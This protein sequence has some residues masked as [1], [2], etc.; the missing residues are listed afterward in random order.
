MS[1]AFSVIEHRHEVH[2]I[3][4]EVPASLLHVLR[5]SEVRM[6]ASGVPDHQALAELRRSG[7]LAIAV[8]V[9]YGGAGG[10]AAAVNRVAETVATVNPSVAIIMFQHFAVSARIAEWGTERQKAELLPILAS[11]Q[12]LAASAWSE[13]G[14][15]AAKKRLATTGVPLSGD[16]W[17][18]D[19]AKSFT[20]GAGIA[21][22][23]LVLVQTSVAQDDPTSSY[24]SSG[25][26]FF[27]VRGD[28]PGLV[29]DL[30]LD[31]VGMRGSA[32]GFVSLRECV[33]TDADRLGQVGD[34]AKIIAGVRESGATLGAVSVGIAQAAVDIAA[35]HIATSTSPMLQARR[36]QLVNFSTLIEAARALVVRAGQ[37]SSPNPGT[38][39]LQSKLHAS[40]TAEEVC[41]DISRIVG[42]SG[43]VIEHRLNRLIADARAVALMGPT[44][45]LCREL[46]AASWNI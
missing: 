25:Q 11:G 31:L 1:V 14:A 17:L 26:S 41:L 37:R 6:A 34:A 10:D 7:L 40:I 8:P 30:S 18:L 5:D 32:T 15:G 38:T 4:P 27:L 36:C 23:Y 3:G 9:E 24:G 45:D 2:T 20:T 43:Y 21:D 42:S 19:G 33:V 12:W 16:R 28:N 46:V 29:S 13:P 22:L 44:N 35:A 39:T